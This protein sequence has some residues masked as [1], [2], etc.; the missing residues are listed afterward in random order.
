MVHGVQSYWHGDVCLH[1]YARYAHDGGDVFELLKLFLREHWLYSTG[2]DGE[3]K[4]NLCVVPG[5]SSRP[6]FCAATGMFGKG[7]INFQ[8]RNDE[9][10]KVVEAG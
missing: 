7:K 2:P 4:R 9:R 10:K 1:L 6:M 3:R 8:M 5:P